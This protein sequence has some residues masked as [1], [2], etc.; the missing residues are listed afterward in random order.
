MT[1][2]SLMKVESIAECSPWTILQYFWP[3]FCVL[4]FSW[5]CVCSL[6]PCGHLLGKGWPLG[7]CWWC[8]LYFCYFPW[9]RCGTWLYRFLIFAVFLTSLIDNWSWKPI[10]GL[11]ESGLFTQVL[12]Y[13]KNILHEMRRAK[14]LC[15]PLVIISSI[16]GDDAVGVQWM[17]ISHKCKLYASHI[18][19]IHKV[20]KLRNAHW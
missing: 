18:D 20:V 12:L 7:C 11:L 2:G 9:V 13:I 8:L 10:L 6:L 14:I 19:F 1:N 5:F 15:Y 4:C 17:D 16:L 3:F